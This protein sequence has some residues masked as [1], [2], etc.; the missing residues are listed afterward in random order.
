MCPWCRDARSE[1]EEG[2][3]NLHEAE[4]IGITLEQLESKGRQY[5]S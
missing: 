4:R 2:L 5:D 3:C 1:A